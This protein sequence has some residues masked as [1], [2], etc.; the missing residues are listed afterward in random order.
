[1]TGNTPTTSPRVRIDYSSL[2]PEPTWS[3]RFPRKV[4]ILGY[5]DRKNT[6]FGK[7]LGRLT[8]KTWTIPTSLPLTGPLVL[9]PFLLGPPVYLFIL[10]VVPFLVKVPMVGPPSVRMFL[11]RGT[12]THLY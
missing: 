7:E 2:H 12:D 9:Q 1:M 4:R 6:E 10:S 11:Q 8:R 3:S 5:S